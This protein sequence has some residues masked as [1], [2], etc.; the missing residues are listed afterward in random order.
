MDAQDYDRRTGLMISCSEGHQAIVKRLLRAR[1]DI[2]LE[3]RWSKTALASAVV[4]HHVDVVHQLEEAL[5]AELELGP[6]DVATIE[7]AAI[8][9]DVATSAAAETPLLEMAGK[10]AS[11]RRLPELHEEARSTRLL[12]RSSTRNMDEGTGRL[13]KACAEGD[14][15]EIK[16]VLKKGADPNGA[17]YDLRSSFFY[18]PSS[19]FLSRL[20]PLGCF[21][22]GAERSY[23]R[24]LWLLPIRPSCH[25]TV[26]G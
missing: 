11:R 5:S 17:D 14:E 18:S 8:A 12:M 21:L 16:R 26:T 20:F 19:L 6:G 13:I 24:M 7:V 3:D 4:G 10:R 22:V 15:E 1:P 9:D 2:T 23:L 25:L